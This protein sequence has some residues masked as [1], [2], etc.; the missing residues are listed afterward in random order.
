MLSSL[1]TLQKL[2]TKLQAFASGYQKDITWYSVPLAGCRHAENFNHMLD[3]GDDLQNPTHIHL[4]FFLQ[5]IA[6]H[7]RII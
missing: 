7:K 2:P 5:K 3:E 1:S 4:T 6:S